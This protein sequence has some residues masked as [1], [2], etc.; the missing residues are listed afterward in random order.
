LTL[1]GIAGGFGGFARRFVRANRHATQPQAQ[2]PEQTHE[3]RSL[4]L[5]VAGKAPKLASLAKNAEVVLEKRGLLDTTC[6]VV[7]VLDASASMAYQ[8]ADGRVQEL[9]E[10]VMPLAVHFAEN[11]ALDC[12]IFSTLHRH[13]TPVTLQNVAGYVARENGGFTHWTLGV[14]NYESQI[15]RALIEA[16]R[17]APMP[18]LVLFMSDGGISD[19]GIY[20]LIEK[21]ENLPIF[22]R[23]F[24]IS[25]YDYG[26][27][28]TL[29][30]TP[31][32][33]FNH[34]DFFAIE[35]LH[36]HSA[37][38]LYE[39]LLAGFPEWLVAARRAGVLSQG[40]SHNAQ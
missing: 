17:N 26:D 35:D 24:G 3:P 7:L 33:A 28:E 36:S 6:H 9:V 40:D 18:V 2:Q 22:W 5:K 10:T 1:Q 14:H 30:A 13:L 20:R 27:L 25:G 11:Q 8:Y 23:F 31:D 4:E 15:I 32:R 39:R 12:W 19:T 16:H 34:A 37:S 21:A 38:E 29:G